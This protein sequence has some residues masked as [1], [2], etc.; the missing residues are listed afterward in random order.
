ML[1][2]KEIQ[3]LESTLDCWQM[4]YGTIEKLLE[5]AGKGEKGEYEHF[6]LV[7][8]LYHLN[9]ALNFGMRIVT[10]GEDRLA[11][12]ATANGLT[13]AYVPPSTIKSPLSTPKKPTAEDLQKIS[14]A[15]DEV[16]LEFPDRAA[17]AGTVPGA[18]GFLTGHVMRKM[19][20]K[21]TPIAAQERL[22]ER[23]ALT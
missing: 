16:L 19:G 15:I 1:I 2:A 12:A 3:D 4:D 9:E 23:L 7:M 13:C 8:M 5:F 14:D 22:G 21:G 20:G 10:A 11:T 17:E 6:Y 18:I